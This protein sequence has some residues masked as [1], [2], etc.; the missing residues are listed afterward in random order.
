LPGSIAE[1]DDQEESRPLDI[2]VAELELY[3]ELLRKQGEVLAETT[4]EGELHEDRQHFTEQ[5]VLY[6]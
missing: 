3:D 6:R 2:L 4:N 5:S 1:E